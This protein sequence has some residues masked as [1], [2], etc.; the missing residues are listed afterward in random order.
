M[1]LDIEGKCFCTLEKGHKGD[2][3]A[4]GIIGQFCK[5]WKNKK[6]AN[7]RS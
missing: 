6:H 3:I 4:I 7:K 5:S 2:H 1:C